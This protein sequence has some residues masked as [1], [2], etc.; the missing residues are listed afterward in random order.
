MTSREIRTVLGRIELYDR[1]RRY[2]GS[3]EPVMGRSMCSGGMEVA[4]NRPLI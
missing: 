1:Q 4:G 3:R 2:G